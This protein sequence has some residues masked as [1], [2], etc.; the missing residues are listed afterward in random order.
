MLCYGL[1]CDALSSAVTHGCVRTERSLSNGPAS[2][3]KS[4]LQGAGDAD[5]TMVE[6]NGMLVSAAAAQRR[7][8]FS[9]LIQRAS[10]K[11]RSL[12]GGSL[13][14]LLALPG[15]PAT[16]E[17]T[18]VRVSGDEGCDDAQR[19]DAYKHLSPEVKAKLAAALKAKARAAQACRGVS[20]LRCS[21]HVPVYCP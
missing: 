11:K 16:G 19:M 5:D 1:V 4:G 2:V 14:V 15:S 6:L 3:S 17:R 12:G 21:W 18:V 13:T 10:K 7:Q 8:F 9:A 20:P